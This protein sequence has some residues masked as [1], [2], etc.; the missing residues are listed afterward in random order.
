MSDRAV[1][2]AAQVVARA[3]CRISSMV[4]VGEWDLEHHLRSYSNYT[5]I[6][7]ESHTN[8]IPITYQ[9]HTNHIPIIA[10]MAGGASSVTCREQS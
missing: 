2:R 8:H 10:D 7:Y 5:A 4:P 9:S 3:E 6:T 1:D